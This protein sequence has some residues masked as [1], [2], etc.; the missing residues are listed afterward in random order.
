MGK[1]CQ[2]RKG[3]DYKAYREADYWKY[4]DERLKQNKEKEDVSSKPM[5]E[6]ETK[7][8]TQT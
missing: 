1:G 3:T 6:L 7:A 5:N 8:Y 2:W 4:R